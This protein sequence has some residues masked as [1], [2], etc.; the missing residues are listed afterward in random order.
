M[1]YCQMLLPRMM[2]AGRRAVLKSSRGQGPLT[3]DATDGWMFVEFFWTCTKR[4]AVETEG[5]PGKTLEGEPV[6][7]F[8]AC[9]TY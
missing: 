7:S 9:L 5:P 1:D 6:F 8:V 4:R 2:L 3:H